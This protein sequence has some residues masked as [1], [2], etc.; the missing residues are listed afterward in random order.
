M[1]APVEQL[2]LALRL[3]ARAGFDTYTPGDNAEALA[4]AI[5]WSRASGDPYLFIHGEC[6][7]GKTHL[8]CAACDQ[9]AARGDQVLYLPLANPALE[10]LV[11]EDLEKLDAVAIDDL[12]QIAGSPGWE[13]G[14]FALYNRLRESGGRL[15]A[16]ARA[17]PPALPLG[18]PDLQSRLSAGPAYALKPLDDTGR[19]ALLERGAAER[20]LM[21]SRAEVSYIL[22]RC[23][24]EPAW[25]LRFLDDIDQ[26]SLAEQRQPSI[27]FISRLLGARQ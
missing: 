16:A 12:H 24:R 20:G 22:S 3:P 18:L 4:A 8:L 25:L 17:P 13:A 27:P 5:A 15:L 11:M 10:P 23:P 21:L 14:L 2:A 19:A 1:A 7:T 9:A 26:A 6:G